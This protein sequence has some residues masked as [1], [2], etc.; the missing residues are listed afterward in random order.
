MSDEEY[1]KLKNALLTEEK[2]REKVRKIRLQIESL[3][4]YPL[5]LNKLNGWMRNMKID[6]TQTW[7]QIDECGPSTPQKRQV[8]LGQDDIEMFM[9]ALDIL[10]ENK[11]K[12][13]KKLIEEAE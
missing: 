1:E 4:K 8:S 9:E 2:R 6:I 13:L 10:V 7:N 11:R 5:G 12:Q 3:E